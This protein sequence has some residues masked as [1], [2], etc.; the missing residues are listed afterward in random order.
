M[1]HGNRPCG[2]HRSSGWWRRLGAL[3]SVLALVA[4]LAQPAS[5]HQ[6]ELA[7]PT[8]LRAGDVGFDTVTLSW[9]APVLPGGVAVTGYQVLIRYKDTDPVGHFRVH[10]EDTGSTRTVYTDRNIEP[11]RR[12][13]YRVKAH[14]TAG[15]TPRSGWVDVN[16]PAAPADA[17]AAPTNLEATEILHDRAVLSWDPPAGLVVEGYQI[18]IRYKDIDPVGHFR[19]LVHDTGDSATGYTAAGLEPSTRH[20]FRVK[21]HTTAGLTPRSGWVDVN[22]PA[23]P[24]LEPEPALEPEPPG[25][26]FGTKSPEHHLR[27]EPEPDSPAVPGAPRNV[28][29]RV[30]T[31]HSG[32]LQVRWDAPTSDG[33]AG[34]TRYVVQWKR[35]TDADWSEKS[36]WGRSSRSGS[37]EISGLVDGDS[38]S[39][40]VL[41]KNSVGRG[42]ASEEVTAV[43]V[44]G[45][46]QF[47]RYLDELVEE[48]GDEHP[49]F[50]E[51]VEYIR[52]QDVEFR[53]TALLYLGSHSMRCRH[54]EAAG[55][56]M[57]RTDRIDIDDDHVRHKATAVHEVA[58][59]Y[60]LSSDAAAAPAPIA[61]A[62]VYFG[63]LLPAGP[64]SYCTSEELYAD[65]IEGLV[66]GGETGYWEACEHVPDSPTAEAEEV[67]KAALK[68]EMP[69]WFDDTYRRDGELDLESLWADMST[70]SRYTSAQ[71]VFAQMRNEFGGYCSSEQA[72]DSMFYNVG[73][74]RNP[75]VDGGC[76]PQAPA[77]L[78]ASGGDGRIDVCWAAPAYDGGRPITG[79]VVQWKS[80]TDADYGADRQMA[81]AAGGNLSATVSGLDNGVAYRV[82]V[83][84]RNG[85]DDGDDTTSNDDW[86]TAAET[87][88][89][90]RAGAPVLAPTDLRALATDRKVALSWVAPHQPARGYRDPDTGTYISIDDMYIERV[91]PSGDW[92]TLTW[93]P[94]WHVDYDSGAVS[95]LDK[96]GVAAGASHCYRVR[97]EASTH[98]AGRWEPRDVYS[99]IMAVTTPAEPPHAPED[100]EATAGDGGVQ[101]RWTVPEQPEWADIVAMRVL[102]SRGNRQFADIEVGEVDWQRGT[103]DYEFFDDTP[104]RGKS[105]RYAVILIAAVDGDK[106]RLT[107]TK[108]RSDT[109]EV[110]LSG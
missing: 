7:A 91:D 69:A 25:G 94:E 96:S 67:V 32:T 90:P 100:L 86:G 62:H 14:T 42:A 107:D 20:V 21:A 3:A 50:V 104:R 56:P 5:A 110:D 88:A 109:V 66:A 89:T 23:A 97:L 27:A 53:V 10:V 49:W 35:S 11:E 26:G 4:T 84:A 73:P 81:V 102:R 98:T 8:N 45:S 95:Y 83:L 58:H 52:E 39:V 17:L 46:E 93:V 31:G 61:V 51:A 103:T 36:V 12:H 71:T 15:L 75:W 47:S 24:V 74:V 19:I 106:T 37:T 54:D 76:V 77:R 9:D 48:I 22:T 2:S 55:I 16:T 101:L 1:N 79:Y 85:H 72:Y 34:I 40:Q 33:G 92:T 59:S 38:Y 43:P 65:V 108:L 87:S 6:E 28:S 82:R 78:A 57:C 44:S 68:G 18:L 99:P 13:V 63:R 80:E 41:A 29:A 70:V 60:T 105:N 30:V 64:S